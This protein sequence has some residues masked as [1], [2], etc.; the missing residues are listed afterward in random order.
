MFQ[1]VD[2]LKLADVHSG[3]GKDRAFCKR[4]TWRLPASLTEVE[5]RK[6]KREKDK[7]EVTSIPL[8]DYISTYSK[9][10]LLLSYSY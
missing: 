10:S 2:P 7:E 8:L 6:R 3:S 4:K 9:L 1:A 5:T